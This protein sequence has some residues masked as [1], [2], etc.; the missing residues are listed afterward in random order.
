MTKNIILKKYTISFDEVFF[1]DEK[2]IEARS[3]KEAEKI[4]MKML[5]NGKIKFHEYP[6]LNSLLLNYEIFVLFNPGYGTNFLKF[7]WKQ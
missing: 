5:K 6:E 2:E 7:Q 3:G 1:Y 4:Y